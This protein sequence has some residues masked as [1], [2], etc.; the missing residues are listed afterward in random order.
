MDYVYD[1]VLNFQNNY[2]EF[3]EWKSSDKIINVKKVPIYKIS[4]KDYLNIKE[5]SI[6][7]DKISLPKQSKLFLVTNGSEIMGLLINNKGQIIK[8]SSLIFEESDDILSDI[9]DIKSINIK[10]QIDNFHKQ[11]LMSRANEEKMQYIDN[12]LKNIDKQKDE[13]FLKYLYYDIYDT[14]EDDIDKI[15]QDLIKL[16]NND[17]P[18]MYY[19]LKRVNLELNKQ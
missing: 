1:I 12:C 14:K 19:Y 17:I 13:Y 16:A 7:I 8:K 5:H 18:K 9:E 15:Y 6:T 10:Y 11:Q 4:T 2:Y 3:Y